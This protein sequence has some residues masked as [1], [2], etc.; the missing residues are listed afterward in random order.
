[1]HAHVRAYCL[2]NYSDELPY[3]LAPPLKSPNEWPMSGEEWA[4]KET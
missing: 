4:H 1:M 3:P 2:S